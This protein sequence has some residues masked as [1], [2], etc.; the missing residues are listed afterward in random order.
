MNP[1][2][3][4]KDG[5]GRKSVV[6]GWASMIA[7]GLLGGCTYAED[8]AHANHCQNAVDEAWD[9]DFIR[10]NYPDFSDAMV[11]ELASDPDPELKG[12][13]W[14]E[15]MTRRGFRCAPTI[16]GRPVSPEEGGEFVATHGFEE[17]MERG[18]PAPRC[19]GEGGAFDSPY[20]T[21]STVPRR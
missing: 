7:L 16:D 11:E 13:D 5:R 17:F 18:G 10:E 3:L 15:C 19:A 20:V 1:Q 21:T 8:A 4:L 12:F 2:G 14:A 6:L 9:A